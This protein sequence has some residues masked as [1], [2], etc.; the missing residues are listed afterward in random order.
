MSHDLRFYDLCVH[1]YPEGSSTASRMALTARQLGYAGIG[2]ILH[3]EHFTG[4]EPLPEGVLRGVEIVAADASELRRGIDRYRGRAGVI[5]VHGG[6]EAINRAA[7]EDGRV[8]VLSHPQDARSGG[9]NHII[10][11]LAAEK[12]V[13]IEFSLFPLVHGRGGTR[14]RTLSGYRTNFALVRKYRAPYVV[15]SGAMSDYDLRDPRSM[16]A[17]CRLFG[18]SEGDAIRGLSDG[19]ATIIRRSAPGHVTDGVETLDG[20]GAGSGQP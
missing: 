15:T 2:S 16:V 20:A 5:A 19:P 8:D 12:R 13:A 9:I 6:E 10:A 3:Q 17:L 18:M 11:R 7:C 1:P 4:K 14:V